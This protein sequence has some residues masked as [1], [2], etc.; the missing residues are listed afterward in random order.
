MLSSTQDIGV[1]PSAGDL[2]PC[3]ILYD[4]EFWREKILAKNGSHQ[5]LADNILANEQNCQCLKQ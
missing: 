1:V 4:T 3:R 2:N 5:K